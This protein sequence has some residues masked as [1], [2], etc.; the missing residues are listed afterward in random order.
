[1]AIAHALNGART[2]AASI[3][4]EATRERVLDVLRGAGTFL[5][6][7]EERRWWTASMLFR[8]FLAGSGTT[9]TVP[10]SLLSGFAPAEDAVRAVDAH[11]QNWLLGKLP[12]SRWGSPTVGLHD[13]QRIV[14]GGPGAEAH[15]GSA[16]R[17]LW[18]ASFP[19]AGIFDSDHFSDAQASIG[20][21]TMNGLGRFVI[22]RHGQVVTASGYIDF[23]ATDRYTFD[24]N[25]VFNPGFR[26]LEP[27]GIGEAFDVKTSAW[28]VPYF[29]RV[30][31]DDQGKP[32]SIAR[33]WGGSD[34]P[35]ALP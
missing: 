22:E 33:Q 32:I 29:A 2:Q 17:V 7:A 4:D 24:K 10:S 9:V 15:P 19:G 31:L 34:I 27:A 5:H 30:L 28:R 23:H 25:D 35:G 14:V 11:F 6:A 8:H 12:D 26:H 13:G 3:S 18:Q 21:G 16:S 1:V 20:G